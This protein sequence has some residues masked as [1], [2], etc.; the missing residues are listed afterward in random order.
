MMYRKLNGER[1]E[2]WEAID[3]CR[4]LDALNVA[5]EHDGMWSDCDCVLPNGARVPWEACYAAEGD[6]NYYGMKEFEYDMFDCYH[7]RSESW[8]DIRGQVYERSGH[9]FSEYTIAFDPMTLEY[10][11]GL[12]MPEFYATHGYPDKPMFV[13]EILWLDDDGDWNHTGVYTLDD[14]YAYNGPTEEV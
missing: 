11:G 2:G 10:R 6:K 13:Y 3:A 4:R 14:R 7:V 8:V 5:E 9:S 1:I 12:M